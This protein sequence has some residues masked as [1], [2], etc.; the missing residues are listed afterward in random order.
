MSSVAV[1]LLHF[2]REVAEL[3]AITP[4]SDIPSA[5]T[6]PPQTLLPASLLPQKE[7]RSALPAHDGGNVMQ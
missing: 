6:L 7:G 2:G 5:P 1:Q 4:C 3:T